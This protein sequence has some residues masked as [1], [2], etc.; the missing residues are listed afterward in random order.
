MFFYSNP[1][2]VCL[3]PASVDG[4]FIFPYFE[5]CV[6]IRIKCGDNVVTFHRKGQKEKSLTA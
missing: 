5:N 1:V 4:H 2:N 6:V 3:P